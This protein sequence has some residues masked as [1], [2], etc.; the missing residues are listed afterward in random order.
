[1]TTRRR[2]ILDQDGG[3]DDLLSLA[4]LLAMDHVELVGVV[5]TPADCF[6]GPA[7]SATRKL[8]RWFGRDDVPIAAG[9]L[10]GVN[11]FPGEWRAAPYIIDA[12]PLLNDDD[13]ELPPVCD[14]P[15]DVLIARLLREASDPVTIV[16]TGPPSHVAAALGS[17]AALAAKVA[18]IA[19]MGG[20]LRV[21]GNVVRHEHDGSA[22]WNAYWDPPA[23]A[24]LWAQPVPITLVPL[25][26]TNV[27]PV[28]MAFLQR[29]ARLRAHPLADFAGQCWAT[30]VGTI[31]SYEYIY[32]MWD[33]LTTGYLGAPGLFTFESLA[34]VVDVAPPSAGRIRIAEPGRIVKVATH[35]D[36]TGFHEYLLR[37]LARDP[38]G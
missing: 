32:F 9:R 11:A 8:L 37:L 10:H 31:P 13:R 38:R 2:V 27:V 34:T 4:M 5:V 18:E 29:L 26:A 19:W 33:T 16:V 23:V 17:D 3:V 14:E 28:S 22:E 20:A 35:A 15:G 1:M 24:A 36:A 12:L 25:D 6:L 7:L 21:R 30:T